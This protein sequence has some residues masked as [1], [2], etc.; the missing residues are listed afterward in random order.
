MKI[1]RDHL[2]SDLE[3]EEFH[4][5]FDGLAGLKRTFPTRSRRP[6]ARWS[7]ERSSCFHSAGAASA[8]SAIG[9]GAGFGLFIISTNGKVTSEMIVIIRKSFE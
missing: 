2:N 8:S 4:I 3:L 6:C 1:L 5:L 7:F 9:G